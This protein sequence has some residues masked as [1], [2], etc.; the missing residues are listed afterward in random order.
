ML[1]G[2]SFIIKKLEEFTHKKVNIGSFNISLPLNLEIRKLNI[3]GLAEADSVFISPSIIGLM[4]G[5][6]VFNSVRFINPKLTYERLIAQSIEPAAATAS[7]PSA[8]AK[9]KKKKPLSL[10]FKRLNIKGGRID[11]IDRT[12]GEDGLKI[13][14][15]DLDFNLTNLYVLPYSGV[16]TFEL[17]G[18]IPWQ[19]VREEGKIEVEGWLNFFKKNMEAT[20]KIED[21]DGIY[22]YPY[23]SNWVDLE[24][25]RIEKANLNFSSD[26]H[27]LNNNLTADCHLEL[28]DIVRRPRPDDQPQEKAEKIT[29]AVLDIFRALNQG[30]IVLDFTIRTKMDKP[31][32]GFGNIKMAFENKL[33]QARGGSGFKVQDVLLF[34]AKVLEETVK[35][36]AD[37]SKSLIEGVFAVGNELKK[38]ITDKTKKEPDTQ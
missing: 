23:Y 15:K 18:K 31:E 34:P 36:A 7:V 35:N 21:I 5:R 8:V 24:K 38:V 17:K 1:K 12:V 9:P 16:T 2:Q 19:K 20:L 37:V 4:T 27:G 14:L 6:I 33:T 25:A 26:I 13:T 3:E 11:F 10:V 28:T 22:L 32:F 30:K 29:D